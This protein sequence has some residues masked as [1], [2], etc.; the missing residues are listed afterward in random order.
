[1][2]NTLWLTSDTPRRC[3]RNRLWPPGMVGVLGSPSLDHQ[4][5]QAATQLLALGMKHVQWKLLDMDLL[6]V[7][8]TQPGASGSTSSVPQ[9][10]V[11]VVFTAAVQELFQ[12]HGGRLLAGGD[13]ATALQLVAML[14][15]MTAAQQQVRRTWPCALW[16][17]AA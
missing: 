3:A 16:A 7:G 4:L 10:D 8:L 9:K 5:Q 1:M 11:Y 17:S 6:D 2:C 15:G 14:R 13:P 12:R